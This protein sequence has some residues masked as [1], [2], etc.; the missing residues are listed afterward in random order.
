MPRRSW[1]RRARLCGSPRRIGSSRTVNLNGSRSA[2]PGSSALNAMAF[3]GASWPC[4]TPGERRPLPGRISSLPW[5][6]ASGSHLRARLELAWRGH[7]AR[8]LLVL[9]LLGSTLF[10]VFHDDL[11]RL[12]MLRERDMQYGYEDRIAVACGA[13]LDRE[14][15]R[16]LRA[17]SGRSRPSS[18]N[19]RP[20]RPNLQARPASSVGSTTHA[21]RMGGSLVGA[22]TRWFGS[23]RRCRLTVASPAAKGTAPPR[24]P[25]QSRPRQAAA[26]GGDRIRQTAGPRLASPM[27]SSRI[28]SGLD[29]R[30]QDSTGRSR[31]AG[32]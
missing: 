7:A 2:P 18:T 15:T 10:L 5:R 13:Q 28:R 8:P 16:Q 29:A 23:G 3:G 12:L 14:T 22:P 1:Q 30:Q 19:W 20:A 27:L 11:R 4:G 6:A 21:A 26:R 17:R 9:W 24:C 31:A 32:P 25:D